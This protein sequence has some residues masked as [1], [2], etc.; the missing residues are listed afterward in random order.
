TVGFAE[1][2][3]IVFIGVEGANLFSLRG[4]PKIAVDDGEDTFFRHQREQ[5]RRN[6]VDAGKSQRLE[7]R[8]DADN[9]GLAIT[10]DSAAAKLI[11][12]VKKQLPG[13]L[14]LLHCH[15]N[16]RARILVLLDD[17]GQ[18]NCALYVHVVENERLGTAGSTYE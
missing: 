10:S 3:P 8:R 5:P 4:K 13:T 18:A 1:V 17:A 9:F 2:A 15:G 11:V 12:V 14:T 6:Y 7:V 16:Q